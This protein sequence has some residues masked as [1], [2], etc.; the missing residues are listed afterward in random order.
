GALPLPADLADPDMITTAIGR[1]ATE[2]GGIDVVV[3]NAA[4]AL[5]GSIAD[6]PLE[7]WQRTLDINL[8]GALLVIR[9][10][11]PDLRRSGGAAVV[12]VSSLQGIRG[13]AGWAGYAAS[14]A[15]LVG[16]TR[17][18][19][20]EFAADGIR[21]NAVAPATIATSMNQKILREAE[22]PAAVE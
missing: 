19:A 11:L 17:Q 21:V 22:D 4:V 16:L 20:V 3:N 7:A 8:R 15:A 5:P 2:L 6:L 1:V 9:A 10:A 12:N 18:A 14:K 13:F